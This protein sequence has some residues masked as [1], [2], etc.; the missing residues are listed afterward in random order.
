MGAF[1]N[2]LAIWRILKRNKTETVERMSPYKASITE[3]LA[4]AD[5]SPFAC[6]FAA[7]YV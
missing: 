5:L 4:R 2:Y 6:I 1:Q 3:L 7:L